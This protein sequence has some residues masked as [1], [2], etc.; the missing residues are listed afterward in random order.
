MLEITDVFF[1]PL[2]IVDVPTRSGKALEYAVIVKQRHAMHDDPAVPAA[3]V[4]Q[5]VFQRE[6]LAGIET[7]H[8]GLQAAVI[9]VEMDTLE[10]AAAAFLGRAAPGEGQPGI[11]E[12]DAG[13]LGIGDPHQGARRL[14]NTVEIYLME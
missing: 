13:A 11:V 6:R 4:V 9:V 1:L 5:P 12:P 3:V 7:D 10:P 8:I 14:G 2:Q